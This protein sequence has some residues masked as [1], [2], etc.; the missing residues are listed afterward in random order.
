VN[1]AFGG[2]RPNFIAL[3]I[4]ARG[5]VV[6]NFLLKLAVCGLALVVIDWLGVADALAQTRPGPRTVEGGAALRRLRV[7][8][9]KSQTLRL[10]SAF[11]DVLVGSSDIADVIPLSDQTLY[12]LGKKVGTTNVSVL[13]SNRRVVAVVDVDVT[14]DTASVADKIQ[15]GGGASGIRVRNSGEQLVLEGDA[16]D[17]TTVD[18]AVQIARSVSP[19]GVINATRVASPQQVMLK[20]RVVEVN[21]SAARELGFR[22]DWWGRNQIGVPNNSIGRGQSVTSI[23][24]DIFTR[25]ATAAITGSPFATILAGFGPWGRGLD[26]TISALEEKGLV[27][28]LAEPNLVAQSGGIAEFHAGGRIPYT[29]P[30]Q[31]G[32][33]GNVVFTIQWQDFG[34]RLRFAPTVLANGLINMDLTPEV[35]DV[36]PTLSV[37]VGGGQSV[38][39]LT[40]RTARTTIELRDGQ[41]FAMAGLLQNINERDIDQFPWLGSI[42]VIGTLFRSTAFRQRETELV[43]IVTPHLVRPAKPG[44]KLDTP[45][46]TTLPSNDLDLFL[47]GKLEVEK[48]LSPSVATPMQQWILKNGSRIQGPY[49][50]MLDPQPSAVLAATGST[51]SAPVRT[52]N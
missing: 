26:L 9:N 13:D 17:A 35:S 40:I 47:V 28:R 18:R 5:F 52:K 6:T 42:P 12:V 27:R 29:V 39:G 49:G 24:N 45:L 41:S 10:E 31:A 3:A 48:P 25:T 20:V 37:P 11:S 1:A 2:R 30:Q 14:P 51:R 7:T 16:V 38:P 33:G 23:D 46:D 44:D 36:D 43:V 50:H 4:W 32:T 8:I 34:V 19:T 15:A 21:R 22:W